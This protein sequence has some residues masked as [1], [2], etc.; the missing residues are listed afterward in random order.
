MKAVKSRRKH[1]VTCL[2]INGWQNRESVVKRQPR[3]RRI[4]NGEEP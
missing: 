2:T 3:L 4:G 1:R